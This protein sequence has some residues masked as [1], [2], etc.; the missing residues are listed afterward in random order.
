[1]FGLHAI[2]AFH[3]DRDSPVLGPRDPS[4][5]FQIPEVKGEMLGWTVKQ[6]FEFEIPDPRL[7]DVSTALGVEQSEKPVLN[8][9]VPI[10][11]VAV[12]GLLGEAPAQF[13]MGLVLDI[14]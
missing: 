10:E 7:A 14:V 6:A 8:V 5:L 2:D 13:G 4:F 12:D 1:M 11:S 9:H 3:G